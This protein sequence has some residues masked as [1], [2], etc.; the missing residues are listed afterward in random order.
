VR[1]VTEKNL[2]AR[3]VA[4]LDKVISASDTCSGAA[5]QLTRCINPSV[6]SGLPRRIALSNREEIATQSSFA[7]HFSNF[8]AI[9]RSGRRIEPKLI[10]LPPNLPR[11][12]KRTTIVV[13]QLGSIVALIGSAN[14]LANSASA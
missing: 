2:P 12:V 9:F 7:A 6:H 13:P 3:I 11:S 10:C 8:S 5:G 14:M 4:K 1:I